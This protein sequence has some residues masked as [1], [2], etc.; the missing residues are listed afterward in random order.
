MTDITGKDSYYY[1]ALQYNSSL[2]SEN[3]QIDVNLVYPILPSAGDYQV[4][5]NKANI[6]LST[7]PLTQSNIPLKK[8]SVGLRNGTTE[9]TA[10]VKQIGTQDFNFIY[11]MA[12]NGTVSKS[13]YTS[14]G[15][16][17]STT[18]IGSIST[19]WSGSIGGFFIDDYQNIY[20]IGN[21]NPASK[22]WTDFVVINPNCSAIIYQQT[23]ST[24]HA[25][26]IDRQQRI[27]IAVAGATNEVLVF[28]NNNTEGSV[29]LSLTT[30]ISLDYNGDYFD[31]IQAICADSNLVIAS[32]VNT[33]TIYETTTF[34]PLT[35]FVDT[36][37]SQIGTSS[38]ID[39]SL[40]RFC[41][42]DIGLSNNFLFGTLTDNTAYIANSAP[43]QFVGGSWIS[44]F[45]V[46]TNGYGFGVGLTNETWGFTYDTSTGATGTPFLANSATNVSN[47]FESY[48]TNQFFGTNG[49]TLY[50]WNAN[51]T[52]SN[53][54]YRV[55]SKYQVSSGIT[56]LSTDTNSIDKKST[57]VGSDNNLYK[58]NVGITP[59]VG[60][61]AFQLN[62]GSNHLVQTGFGWNLPSTSIA[63]TLLQNDFSTG[64]VNQIYGM[65]KN[66]QYLYVLESNLTN[67]LVK[68]YSLPTYAL[69]S[70]WTY[71][72][73]TYTTGNGYGFADLKNGYF[74]ISD[75]VQNIYIFD[76]TTGVDINSGSPTIILP[77]ISTAYS[78]AQVNMD[79]IS[80][81]GGKYYLAIVANQYIYVYDISTPSSPSV[82]VNAFTITPSTTTLWGWSCAWQNNFPTPTLLVSTSSGTEV[83]PNLPANTDIWQITF[84]LPT[85]WT[86]VSGVPLQT[87]L[88]MGYGANSI[89]CNKD[90]GEYYA[91]LGN[92]ADGFNG[93]VNI[94]NNSTDDLTSILTL[95][96]PSGSITSFPSI[97]IFEDNDYTYSFSQIT[98]N[99]P[100]L[101]IAVSVDNPN[102]LFA[103]NKTDNKIYSGYVNG[104]AITF[105]KY[106]LV[107]DSFNWATINCIQAPNIPATLVRDY[108]ISS[109][110]FINTYT[111][112]SFVSSMARNE[113]SGE[114]FACY[115]GVVASLPPTTL[116]PPNFTTT[117][118]PNAKF[119]WGKNGLD[120]DAGQTPIYRM[121]VL[122]GLINDAFIEA[123]NKLPSSTF[124][125]APSLSL[126]YAT[127]LL[128]LTYSS[129]Y[130]S[131][132]SSSK[133]ILLNN[134]LLQLVNFISQPDTINPDYN[135]LLLKAGSTSSTQ[136]NKSIYIFNNLDKIIFISNSIFVQGSFFQNNNINNIIGSI[137]IVKSAQGY[138]DNIGET[139]QYQPNFLRTYI[140]GSNNALQRIQLE[141]WY[142]YV[143]G[144][145]Y[146]LQLAPNTNWTAQ[147]IFPKR[148]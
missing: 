81:G 71:S 113:V 107:P 56:I 68:K 62:T 146:K 3:A 31:T 72:T 60:V 82:K 86:V 139:L 12:G 140:L 138:V 131:P 48:D 19:V 119:I 65:F 128:T 104:T 73:S 80:D 93:T 58:S 32:G 44:N 135:L 27:Y 99:I 105:V 5:I 84:N 136:D 33:I 14:S 96:E 74:A 66:G 52:N 59:K 117:G 133:G 101:S 15:T 35:T 16:V 13:Q 134:A 7:I 21:P 43:S 46:Q 39:S 90:V 9:T 37:I 36:N 102:H 55:G 123:Y 89:S 64:D 115:T 108:S 76:I 147:L 109:Q 98:S 87:G 137:D 57:V 97:C 70:T 79:A 50:A 22:H 88:G 69:I 92:F 125:E 95:F 85:D 25:F 106:A 61:G 26:T 116:I 103:V 141:I 63:D 20:I 121:S 94:Y 78:F 100:L 8:Y 143:D 110:T 126:D 145:Q 2:T 42:T 144:T 17:L 28:N 122:I 40:D 114:F 83:L 112:S 130:Y 111:P 124:S 49:A 45:D 118:I 77:T 148:F 18:T 91:Y 127:G 11:N 29:S 38:C 51:Y 47:L 53:L 24:I 67:L 54:Y 4:A 34:T 129:D 6:D 41:I 132:A 1:S 30:T 10:Y 23:Y 120:I 142:Q 75:S